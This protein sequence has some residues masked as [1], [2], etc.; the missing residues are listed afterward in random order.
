MAQPP[1]DLHHDDHPT[2]IS[3]NQRNGLILFFIYLALYGGFMLISAFNPQVMGARPFG[4]VNLAVLYG[5]GLIVSAL[6]L[7]AVY[8]YLSRPPKRS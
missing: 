4:G 1:P 6:L 2:T 7:A 5:L 3:R 8:M